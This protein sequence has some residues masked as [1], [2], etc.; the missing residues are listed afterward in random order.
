MDQRIVIPSLLVFSYMLGSVPFGLIVSRLYKVDITKVGSGN[1]GT[2]NVLRAVGAVPAVI[3]F[4]LD[5]LKGYAPVLSALYIG[6]DPI[7]VV[8][9]GLAAIIG[10]SFSVFM[11]FRGGRGVAAGLGMLLGIAPDIFLLAAVMAAIIIG[12][13][14]YVSLASIVTSIAVAVAMYFFGKPFPYVAVTAAI[15]VLILVRHIPNVKRLIRGEENKI[16][17]KAQ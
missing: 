15:A 1:I 17:E 14:R 9:S 4:V 11:R 13:T 12:F 3:V 2:T 10:H 7:W 16:G 6:L 8:S 5:F